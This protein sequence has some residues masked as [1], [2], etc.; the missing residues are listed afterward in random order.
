MCIRD[1]LSSFHFFF[2]GCPLFFFRP[3]QLG[4][5]SLLHFSLCSSSSLFF[6]CTAPFCLVCCQLRFRW[7]HFQ[8]II[9]RRFLLFLAFTCFISCAGLLISPS[10]F[11]SPVP[12]YQPSRFL[13][14]YFLPFWQRI[15]SSSSPSKL[16]FNFTLLADTLSLLCLLLSFSWLSCSI[17]KDSTFRLFFL[18]LSWFLSFVFV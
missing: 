16:F 3:C 5:F 6:S 14:F 17:V 1:R 12:L 8:P 7:I 11:Y 4:L 2:V 15:P 9:I 18:F 13:P 10:L